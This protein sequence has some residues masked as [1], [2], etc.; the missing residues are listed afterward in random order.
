MEKVYIIEW[1]RSEF[2]GVEC[3]KRISGVIPKFYLT[4]GEAE[5]AIEKDIERMTAGVNGGY[6]VRRHTLDFGD[7]L[8][9]YRVSEL[10]RG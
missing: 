5:A 6:D 1:E 8:Y 2:R 3:V 7:V 9:R 10:E 4:A